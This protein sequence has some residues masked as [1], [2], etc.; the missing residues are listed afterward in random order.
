MANLMGKARLFLKKWEVTG[1][2]LNQ[3][4]EYFLFVT[5]SALNQH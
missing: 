3:S 5:S 1:E 2:Q 4:A